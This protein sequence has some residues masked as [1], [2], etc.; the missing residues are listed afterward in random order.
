MSVR[1]QE[2]IGLALAVTGPTQLLPWSIAAEV[3]DCL[4]NPDWGY[5]QDHGRSS[6]SWLI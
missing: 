5:A 2:E 4:D 6:Q 1:L 3:G